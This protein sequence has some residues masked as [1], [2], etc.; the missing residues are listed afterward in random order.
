MRYFSNW[1]IQERRTIRFELICPCMQLSALLR[2]AKRGPESTDRLWENSILQPKRENGPIQVSGQY[3][4]SVL[5]SIAEFSEAAVRGKRLRE[6]GDGPADRAAGAPAGG[7]GAMLR[8]RGNH[9]EQGVRCRVIRQYGIISRRRGDLARLGEREV[10]HDEG[11]DVGRRTELYTP[12]ATAGWRWR[13]AD[14][15]SG[16]TPAARPLLD[17]LN[18]RWTG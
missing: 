9:L 15:R 6:Q 14:A 3:H 8:V 7:E 4:H 2:L 12:S 10:Q 11:E 1:I 16:K 5:G 18:P 17:V 13:T